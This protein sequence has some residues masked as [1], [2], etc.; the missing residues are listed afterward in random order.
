MLGTLPIFQRL[1][2]GTRMRKNLIGLAAAAAMGLAPALAFAE[3]V[4]PIAPAGPAGSGASTTA[5]AAV[6]QTGLVFLGALVLVGA[7]V[8]IA[9]A[10]SHGSSSASQTSTH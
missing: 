6:S 8:G 2:L 4:A 5:Q 3:D 7:A 1:N 10:T 9:L